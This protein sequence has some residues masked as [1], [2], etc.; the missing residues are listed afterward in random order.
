[1]PYLA[2][3]PRW[4]AAERNFWLGAALTTALVLAFQSIYWIERNEL[5][6]TH[7]NRFAIDASETAM[8]YFTIPHII[9]GFLFSVTSLR[10]R[11]T[12]RR[13]ITG[14]LLLLGAAFC[15]IYYRYD[16]STPQVTAIAV[17]AYFLVH[18]MRDESFFYTLLGDAPPGTSKAQVVSL[19]RGLIA[20]SII[21]VGILSWPL[22]VYGWFPKAAEAAPKGL[23]TLGQAAWSAIPLIAWISAVTWFLRAQAR[24]LAG[25]VGELVRLHA[26][27]FRL[28]GGVLLYLALAMIWF[29]RPYALI[30]LHVSVWY[31]FTIR[32]LKSRPPPANVPVPASSL[33][34]TWLW[35]R[36]TPAGF[37]TLHIGMAAFLIAVGILWIYG[38]GGSGWLWYLLSPKVFLY[39][40]I[41]HIT[42]SFVPR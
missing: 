4:S 10:N 17:Y 20:L 25:G 16:H 30:L 2:V 38:L 6:R 11:S 29:G 21:G 3:R 35:M 32:S 34:R 27:L 28:I 24:G 37:N 22:I 8:R 19:S 26:P 13:L 39:W 40:T 9:I 36:T 7:E 33:G 42:V 23:N 18:E 31:V 1:M 5:G 14:A 12:P 41:M 15:A